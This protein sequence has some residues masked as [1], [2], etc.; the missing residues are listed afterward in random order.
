LRLQFAT[1]KFF[2]D[3]TQTLEFVF[4]EHKILLLLLV[5]IYFME[6][7]IIQQKIY[8]IRGQKVMLDF[9]LAELYDVPTGALNQGVKRNV[10]RF[11]EDFMF[12]LSR[13]EYHSLRSQFVILEGKGNYSKYNPYAFT[14][15]GVTM[16]AS[17]LKS[18]KAAK[19]NIAIV[20]AFISLRQFALNYKELADQI[21]E[22]RL[23]VEDHSE[24]LTKIYGAIESLMA[25]KEAQQDWLQTRERIGFKA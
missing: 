23:T 13:E 19:M 10:E 22:I 12:Q 7:E 15:H 24:Q 6:L 18:E 8:E 11:P 9:D 4:W 14:E 16:L 21:Q 20:R 25:A 2:Q 5:K 3:E 1:D 17:I